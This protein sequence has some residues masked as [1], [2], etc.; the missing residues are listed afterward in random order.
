MNFYIFIFKKEI[1]IC[2][3][4][5]IIYIYI[6]I[7]IGDVLE[8]IVNSYFSLINLNNFETVSYILK[9]DF[10]NLNC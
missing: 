8:H 5:S 1:L 3:N 9:R 4:S 2:Y 10:P 7:Y 6:Y